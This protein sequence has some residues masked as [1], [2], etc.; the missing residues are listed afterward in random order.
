M[1]PEPD[2]VLTGERTLPGIPDERYWFQRHVVAYRYAVEH[3]EASAARRVLDAGC[4][5]GYGLALLAAGGAEQVIGADLDDTVVAH[6]RRVYAAEDPRIEV[7]AAELMSLPLPDDAIDLTVSF[8]VIE[9]LHDIPGYLRSLARVTRPGGTVLIATPNRLTFTP[10]SDHPVNPFHTREFTGEELTR[11]LTASG[12]EV[13]Q[14][15][16]VHHGPELAAVEARTGVAFPE[17][18]AGDE[19]GGWPD[20]LRATV[21]AVETDW[22]ELRTSELDASLDLLADCRVPGWAGT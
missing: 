12:F 3:L 15:L 2:L 18:L 14:L 21:H 4:G 1:T 16:G 22:F 20:W 7:V 11:E 5:E 17:L 13:R 6:A 9:H 19:P 10:D 8:Q